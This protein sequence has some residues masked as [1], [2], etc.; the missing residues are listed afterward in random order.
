VNIHGKSGGSNSIAAIWSGGKFRAKRAGSVRTIVRGSIP[1]TSPGPNIRRVTSAKS[2][3]DT[4]TRT[5]RRARAGGLAVIGS[6]SVIR[7]AR[8]RRTHGRKR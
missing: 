7:D 1:I 8:P 4:V 2:P 5:G 6:V 3:V